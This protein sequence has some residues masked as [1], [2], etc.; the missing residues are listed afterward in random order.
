MFWKRKKKQKKAIF[1]TSKK[2]WEEIGIYVTDKQYED[3]CD[4]NLFMA[5][6][7]NRIPVHHIMLVLKTLGLL[8]TEP[9]DNECSDYS[10][11]HT[12]EDFHKC[13]EAKFGQVK[14]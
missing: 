1:D 9:P 13:L 6:E 11:C 5:T 10:D 14:E 3:L 2:A 7:E 8:P 12:N 4:I